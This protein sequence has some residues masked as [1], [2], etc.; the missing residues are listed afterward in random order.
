MSNGILVNLSPNSVM[1]NSD[2]LRNFV[3]PRNENLTFRRSFM[4]SIDNNDPA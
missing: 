4:L 3:Y 1:N 2:E